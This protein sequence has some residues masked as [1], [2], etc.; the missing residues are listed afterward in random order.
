MS[1]EE[2][3]KILLVNGKLE[4]GFAIL[5]M[6]GLAI[7]WISFMKEIQIDSFA[8]ILI[9]FFGT[10]TIIGLISVILKVLTYRNALL[11]LKMENQDQVKRIKKSAKYTLESSVLD[12]TAVS[13]YTIYSLNYFV[14]QLNF[15]TI[16]SW[17]SNGVDTEVTV[18]AIIA[19]VAFAIML[20][21]LVPN[22]ITF[23]KNFSYSLEENK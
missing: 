18:S 3:L 2:R 20:I 10:V 23:I 19:V 14:K 17:N 21:K 1:I 4:F 12:L 16:T 7:L 8:I 15:G 11:A 13:I 5:Y 22:S 9:P 6:L